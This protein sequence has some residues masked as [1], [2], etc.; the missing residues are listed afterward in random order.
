ML[1]RGGVVFLEGGGRVSDILP[2]ILD[3]FSDFITSLLA[4]TVRTRVVVVVVV[5]PFI[6][7]FSTGC[8][9]KNST[10]GFLLPLDIWFM[11]FVFV[12]SLPCME[13]R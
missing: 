9:D 4:L 12:S 10:N 6:G 11:F 8:S 1:A 5:E 2:N 13:A 3:N 7:F